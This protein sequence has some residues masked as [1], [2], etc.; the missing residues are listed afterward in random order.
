MHHGMWGRKG[1]LGEA[2]GRAE[3]PIGSLDC[4]AEWMEFLSSATLF[5]CSSILG[6]GIC[7]SHLT[8]PHD[9]VVHL[10]FCTAYSII[11]IVEPQ[12]AT[13]IAKAL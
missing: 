5:S 6:T 8:H 3:N 11:A 13:N 10:L 9:M 12:L 7:L 1:T 4:W 2:D